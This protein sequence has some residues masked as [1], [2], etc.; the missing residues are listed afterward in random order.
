[1]SDTQDLQFDIKSIQQAYISIDNAPEPYTVIAR[2]SSVK[3]NR[4]GFIINQLGGDYT[5][6]QKNPVVLP[7]HDSKV[8]PVGRAYG[9]NISES[10]TV[11]K[12]EFN[13]TT[14]GQ[15]FAMLYKNGDM[16]AFSTGIMPLEF[17]QNDDGTYNIDKW[18]LLEISCVTVPADPTALVLRNCL[19][20]VKG[21]FLKNAFEKQLFDIYDNEQKVLNEKL[22]NA[23]KVIAENKNSLEIFKN[24]F[25]KFSSKQKDSKNNEILNRINELINK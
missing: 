5:N 15:D 19:E 14:D 17:T 9:F 7:F 10:Q 1:M 23:I 20:N 12:V 18:E 13:N 22:E 8:K 25:K 11:C 2:V 21:N 4:N 16:K 3:P 24:E 6:Y